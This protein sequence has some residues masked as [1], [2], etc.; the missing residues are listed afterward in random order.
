MYSKRKPF[1]KWAG[2]KYNLS[3]KI[4]GIAEKYIDIENIDTYIEPFVGGGGMLFSISNKY[5]FDKIII[6][7]INKELINTYIQI[8]DKLEEVISN[9][10]EIEFNYNSLDTI[11]EKKDFYYKLRDD[12]NNNI[13]KNIIDTWQA[14][15]FISLNKL[16]FNG[17]Y[18]VNSK[19]LFN[20]P[21]GQRKKANIFEIENLKSVS[22]FLKNIE[23]Y[24]M[25]YTE[26]IKYVDNN[27][28]VYF[29]SPYR[30]L[31]GSNS[32]TT[33][34]KSS[35]NDKNQKELSK[36]CNEV[37]SL[38]GKFIL[39]NSDPKQIDEND[40]F[41]DDLY[42]DYFINRIEASRNIGANSSSRGNVSEIVVVG[43]EI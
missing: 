38:G 12:F 27:S 5:S 21:F 35:F 16:D 28:L 10:S 6:S 32:F 30:P 29:D 7:D 19:G 15:L 23:I 8:R 39:S 31:P 2:G 43:K 22:D 24:N 4:L 42:K 17:L 25:D 26:C 40:N 33:Y 20:V 36:V 14:S 34:T 18:R 13:E 11:D 37:I 41:F 9:L 3:D 1:V